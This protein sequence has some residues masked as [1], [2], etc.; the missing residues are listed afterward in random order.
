M[1]LVLVVAET[2]EG[3]VRPV[4]WELAAAGAMIR[5]LAGKAGDRLDIRILVPGR[6]P[7][8]AARDIADRTGIDTTALV[9]PCAVTPETLTRGLAKLLADQP[10][11][12][13]IFAHTTRGRET[14]PGLAVHLGAASVSGVI[15]MGGDSDGMFFSRP[16]MDNTRVQTVRPLDD[17]CVVLTLAP[18]T[19]VGNSGDNQ[20]RAVPGHATPKVEQITVPD[21]WCSPGTVR[22]ELVCRDD[23]AGGPDD[24]GDSSAPFGPDIRSAN[25]VVAA[26]QGI[27]DRE[28]LD[29]VVRFAEQFPGA[30]VGA[31]RP[32]VDRGWIPYPRQVGIT[33]ATVAPDLYIAC[34][35]SGSSQHLAGMS[36]AKWVVSINTRAD[37]PICGH[38]DLCIPA[39]AIEFMDAFLDKYS[40]K[41]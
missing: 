8:A 27:G 28:N 41:K 17:T 18:G 5:D 3:R 25:I 21:T 14:A 30:A 13:L 29:T 34:G 11:A 9:W 32:L 31:S 19:A 39:D 23:D 36:G 4:T 12:F 37:A 16:V 15:G 7:L 6:A 33:G 38:S 22:K 2:W 24:P 1:K 40:D 35:I 20:S 10:P 26:G